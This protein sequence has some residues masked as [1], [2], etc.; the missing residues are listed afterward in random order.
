MNPGCFLVVETR[1]KVRLSNVPWKLLMTAC[2][3]AETKEETKA[4]A[5][6]EAKAVKEVKAPWH[7]HL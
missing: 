2:S 6:V 7:K 5:I 3:K 4:K 1:S